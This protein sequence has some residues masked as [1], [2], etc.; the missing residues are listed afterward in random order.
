[1][2]SRAHDTAVRVRCRNNPGLPPSD[3][4][5]APASAMKHIMKQPGIEFMI[6]TSE[7]TFKGMIQTRANYK[8]AIAADRKERNEQE[9]N[10]S[11][12]P[13]SMPP[14]VEMPDSTPG[15]KPGSVSMP[16]GVE[17]PDSTSGSQPGSVSMPPGVEMPDSTSGSKPASIAGSKPASIAGS[18][19]ASIA[20]SKPASIAG[21]TPGSAAGS[22]PGTPRLDPE[23]TH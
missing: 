15:S 8:K 2:S 9:L 18:K 6:K 22:T 16:P 20:G 13:V 5:A 21:S 23:L 4:H 10:A 12:G 3:K 17:M 11:L 1:M 14:G 7:G 19:P